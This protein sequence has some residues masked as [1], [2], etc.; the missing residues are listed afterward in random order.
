MYKWKDI[1]CKWIYDGFYAYA[2][3]CGCGCIENY[4]MA[5]EIKSGDKQNLYL[6]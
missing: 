1:S 6:Y 3:V 2:C 5:Y 4:P